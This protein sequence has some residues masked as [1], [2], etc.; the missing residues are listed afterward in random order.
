[1]ETWLWGQTLTFT[2]WE[3][4]DQCHVWHC[5]SLQCSECKNTWRMELELW[6]S[7]PVLPEGGAAVFYPQCCRLINKNCMSRVDWRKTMNQSARWISQLTPSGKSSVESEAGGRGARGWG[8]AK[9][10]TSETRWDTKWTES[11]VLYKQ[12]LWGTSLNWKQCFL[13]RGLQR[14]HLYHIIVS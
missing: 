8:A 9:K 3:S 1:M 12:L 2:T 14:A 11:P 6:E 7:V 13:Y 5:G 10:N 4:D